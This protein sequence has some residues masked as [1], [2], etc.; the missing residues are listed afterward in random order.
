MSAWLEEEG[1]HTLAQLRL[2]AAERQPEVAPQEGVKRYLEELGFLTA[3]AGA[4]AAAT[5]KK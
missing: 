3:W 4:L 2:A 5:H 1:L